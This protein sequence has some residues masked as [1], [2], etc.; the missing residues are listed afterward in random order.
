VIM[1]I[2]GLVLIAFGIILLTDSFG[3]LSGLLP[4]FEIKL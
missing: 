3:W 2:S 1:I 4:D